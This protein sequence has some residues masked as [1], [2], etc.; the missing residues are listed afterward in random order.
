MVARE[1]QPRYSSLPHNLYMQVIYLIRDYDRM[2]AEYESIV[3]ESPQP[4]DGMPRT[5]GVS[6]PTSAKAIRLEELGKRIHAVES[7]IEIVPNEYRKSLWKNI[8]YRI[9]YDT[10]YTSYRTYGYHKNKM[11]V[12]IARN[13]MWI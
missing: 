10:R 4:P 3:D 5:P 6:D 11:I 2:K 13:M 8:V 7:G 12:T 1:R 9:P